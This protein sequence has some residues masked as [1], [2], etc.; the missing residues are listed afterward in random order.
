FNEFKTSFPLESYEEKKLSIPLTKE[1]ITELDAGQFIINIL[2]ETNSNIIRKDSIIEF[3][4]TPNIEENIIEEGIFVK[5]IEITKKNIGNIKQSTD[6][7]IK[8]SLFSYLFT[9]VKPNPTITFSEGLER[10]YLWEIDLSPGEELKVVSSTNW[11]FPILILILAIGLFFIIKR[12]IERDIV[13]TKKVS[14]VKTKGGEFALR[15][16]LNIKAK[17]NINKLNIIDRLPHLVKLY[18]KFGAIHPD[19]VDM[20]N[21]RIEWNI[22]E[23]NEGEERIFS[24]IIYSHKIGVVGRFE[25]PSAR[26]VYEKN[27]NIKELTSNRAFFIN[28]P[29]NG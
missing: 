23:M 25:L 5:R 3:I 13:F 27:N 4:E 2:I 15:V 8:K 1:K 22:D 16:T 14:Y 10:I 24:Y 26:I 29:R 7:T 6:I 18:E 28:E 17:N 12:T 21:K 19:K 20:Q 9:T 11:F